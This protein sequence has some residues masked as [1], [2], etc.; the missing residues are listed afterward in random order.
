MP[1]RPRRLFRNPPEESAVPELVAIASGKGGV[2]KTW[3]SISLAHALARSRHRVLLF[4]GD[5][6]LANLDIQLNLAPE[7]D[8][9]SVL[10]GRAGLAAAVTTCESTGF[11]VICGRSGS[12]RLAGLP[13]DRLRSLLDDLAEIGTGYDVVVLDLAAG[14]DRMVRE[15]FRRASLRLVVT[16]DDPTALTDAYALMKI[17]GRDAARGRLAVV[18]NMAR[19]RE[20]GRQTFEGLRRIC[21]RFLDT[22]PAFAGAVRRDPWVA[23][24]IRR[25]MPFLTRH[26]TTPAA[27]DI[28]HVA[29]TLVPVR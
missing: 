10:A 16:T 13:E 9:G 21:A 3:L 8:L 1:A 28:E 14:I 17:S 18:I 20:A 2:G 11:D 4:D 6:G 26:P 25:Q 5:L 15:G 12:G 29:R 27:E 7:V 22:E 19:S 24:S 23:E